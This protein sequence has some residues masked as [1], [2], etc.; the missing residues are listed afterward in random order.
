MPTPPPVSEA[1]YLATERQASSKS[2]YLNGEVFHMPEESKTHAQITENVCTW[3]AQ[4]V[5]DNQDWSVLGG[6]LRLYAPEGA[7]YTYPDAALVYGEV[8][9]LPDAYQDTLL[10]PTLLVKVLPHA[11]PAHF[12]QVF[13]LY[14][15]IPSVQHVVLITE[16]SA[17]VSMGS[18]TA[19]GL[20]NVYG[21]SGL[22]DVILL[23]DL[24]LEMP[25]A[26][27]YR[28]VALAA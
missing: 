26:E 11:M 5:G 28:G 18:R 12:Q 15:S 2:E 4:Q 16:Y 14:Y 20:L 22:T 19:D 7:L 17:R 6:D 23:P 27:I 13:E 10:N 21:F 8:Q 25:L 9:T 1:A 3:L 24:G